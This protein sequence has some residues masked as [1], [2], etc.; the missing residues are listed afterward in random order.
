MINV[1]LDLGKLSE[2]AQKYYELDPYSSRRSH[3]RNSITLAIISRVRKERRRTWFPE[4][5]EG[6]HIDR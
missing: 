6:I 4:S 3:K 1:E 2:M 5:D